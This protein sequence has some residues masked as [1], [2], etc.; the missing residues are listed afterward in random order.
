MFLFF[1]L[2]AVK[3]KKIKKKTTK[4]YMSLNKKRGKYPRTIT[5][6]VGIFTRNIY[7]EVN[8]PL[9]YWPWL[10]H[11]IHNVIHFG[12]IFTNFDTFAKIVLSENN[13][14]LIVFKENLIGIANFVQSG[15][16]IQKLKNICP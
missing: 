9:F 3:V 10:I 5:S 16:F 6:F 14:A 8:M 11:W 1:Q 12:L 13:V 4:M 15:L 2:G 7:Y